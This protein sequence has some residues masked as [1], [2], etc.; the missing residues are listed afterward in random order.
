MIA[1][2]FGMLNFP[3]QVRCFM[4]EF[5]KT[6]EIRWSDLDANGHVNYAA[7]IDAAGDLRYRFF[8]AH[9]FP[10]EKFA[11]MGVGPVYTSIHADFLREVRMGETVTITYTLS[12]L[13]PSGARWKVHHDVIKSNRKK[14]VS[15]DLE[16]TLLNLSTR[17][18]VLPTPEL[19][20]TFNLIPRTIDFEVLPE[21]RRM[22]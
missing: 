22:K 17:K 15:L 6:Y 8:I 13:S 2:S 7:Y 9:N 21:L 20:Q 16:G 3:Y 19:L 12:G 10:P 18:P 5:S 1:Q 11:E 4:D 14:A